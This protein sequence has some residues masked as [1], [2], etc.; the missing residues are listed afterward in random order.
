MKIAK[1]PD[2]TRLAFD[3]NEPQEKIDAAAR[4]YIEAT[5]QS[6]KTG[7]ITVNIPEIKLPELPESKPEIKVEVTNAPS[8][9]MDEAMAAIGAAMSDMKE[10]RASINNLC[11]MLDKNTKTMQG[12]LRA[13]TVTIIKQMAVSSSSVATAAS[14][15][16]KT[17]E[18]D[19]VIKLDM[20]GTSGRISVEK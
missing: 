9:K 6:D 2:G 11:A 15:L 7:N 4:R 10:L 17:L 19:K 3:D 20:S 14:D 8:P 13:A 1:M 16:Q 12:E 18:K 5:K